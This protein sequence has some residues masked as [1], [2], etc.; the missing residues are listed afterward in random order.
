MAEPI[1]RNEFPDISKR[2]RLTKQEL[3]ILHICSLIEIC[4]ENNLKQF[5]VDGKTVSKAEF[6]HAFHENWETLK[7]E[8]AVARSCLSRIAEIATKSGMS[9]IL[10]DIETIDPSLLPPPLKIT[11]R[12]QS[13]S[14][15]QT[16]LAKKL[17]KL[18][19]EK[20]LNHA[21]CVQF[22]KEMKHLT[23]S[24]KTKLAIPILYLTSLLKR[25]GTHIPSLHVD[26]PR[27]IPI[28]L[29]AE[30][31]QPW[32]LLLQ[33]READSFYASAYSYYQYLELINSPQEI[34]CLIEL[35][36]DRFEVLPN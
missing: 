18:L 22:L 3:R 20:P 12:K 33:M 31:D 7:K 35:I 19:Q 26:I 8:S 21:H 30:I 13:E 2:Q 16:N 27:M 11:V 28:E 32:D 34:F 36:L 25:E 10:S 24:Q 15:Q 6:L 5:P 23:N 9:T 4:V 14:K 29:W 1:S 17:K